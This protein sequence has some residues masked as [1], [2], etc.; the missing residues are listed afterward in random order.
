[1]KLETNMKLGVRGKFQV[2]KIDVDSGEITSL[3]WQNNL[4]LDSFYDRCNTASPASA[5][6]LVAVGTGNSTPDV[7]QTELDNWLATSSGGSVLAS[8]LPNAS[9]PNVASVTKQFDF[10]QGS[11]VGNIAELG[12]STSGSN[13]TIYSRALFLDESNNPTTISVTSQE[14]LRIVYSLE[15]TLPEQVF[16]L[17]NQTIGGVDTEIK[18]CLYNFYRFSVANSTMSVV[19]QNVHAGNN[20]SDLSDPATV[21][22]LQRLANGSLAALGSPTILGNIATSFSGSDHMTLTGSFSPTQANHNDGIK[23]VAASS[24]SNNRANIGVIFEFTPA[25]PKTSLDILDFTLTVTWV[26]P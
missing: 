20:T 3:P 15:V 8:E 13:P 11:V 16:S 17:P 24:G 22:S 9:S 26:K 19:T 23:Y 1:M 5:T 12:F 18:L 21:Q 2:Q 14:I 25:I 7:T 10:P 6:S 4:I